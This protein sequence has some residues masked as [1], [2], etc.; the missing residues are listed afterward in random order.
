MHFIEHTFAPTRLLLVWQAPDGRDRT[1]FVIGELTECGGIVSFRYLADTDD[2]RNAVEEGFVCHP[3][4][5]KHDVE[6]TGG[7]MDVFMRRLPPRSRSD[8]SKYLEQWRLPAT[9]V[10]TD[11][12]M[13][14]YSGAKLPSDGFSV[15]WPLDEVA[16]P[17]E[18]LLEV[19][20]FRYQNIG[21]DELSVG[22]SV[23]FAPESDNKWDT[24]AL[25]MEVDGR[26]IGYVKRAQRDA[27]MNW[28]T[29]YRVDAVLERF[30]GTAE[31]PIVYVFCRLTE[32][33]PDALPRRAAG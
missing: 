17:G 13:L 31:R 20:G 14:A 29:H 16:A 25:R 22:M 5:P 6:Y 32:R 19:A 24:N 18:V 8:Y 3:A 21:L 9:S 7:V 1:L 2:F 28:L 10:L 23:T 26:R 33:Q 30:N 12:A 27:V 15:V 11:F 4:F